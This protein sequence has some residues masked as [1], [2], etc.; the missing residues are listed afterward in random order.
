MSHRTW[1]DRAGRAWQV[2]PR[3]RSAWDFVPLP[4]N[5]ASQRTARAP[6]WQDDPFELSR[7]ELQKLFD[8]AP[9]PDRPRP[10]SPFDD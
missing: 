8:A 3:S 5:P 1:T 4:G 10:A 9:D 2:R 7:E 6:S